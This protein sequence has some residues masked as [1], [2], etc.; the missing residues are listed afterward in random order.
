MVSF[1]AYPK[2]LVE[3]TKNTV[4][5]FVVPAP[6]GCNLKCSYCFIKQRKELI[7]NSNI[8]LPRD[9]GNFINGIAQHRSI[10][11]VSIQGE[12]PLLKESMPYTKTILSVADELDI[13]A[14]LVTNG[15]CLEHEA[16]TLAYFQ[17]LEELTVSLDAAD[18]EIH[19]KLRG[20]L[21][22]FNRVVAGL[23]EALRYRSLAV[24]TSV[25][26]VLF[27]GEV[28]NLQNVP[29]LL[30]SIGIKRWFVTPAIKISKRGQGGP[31]SDW[32]PLMADLQS[33]YHRACNANIEMIVEDEYDAYGEARQKMPPFAPLRFRNLDHPEGMLRLLPDGACEVGYAL[34]SQRNENALKWKPAS[35]HSDTFFQ[36]IMNGQG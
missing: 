25:V 19:D 10:G 36:L 11:C 20:V 29:E 32:A 7:T 18:A 26:S 8:L 24:A 17:N 28:V 27:P 9:Y 30:R 2:P 3:K 21:G 6:Q 34:L 13:P 22:T 5:T 23:H 12:E 35:Q 1:L 14:A 16:K 31:I 33:L 4:L 15:T